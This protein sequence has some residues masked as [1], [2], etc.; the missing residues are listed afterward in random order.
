M[1]DFEVVHNQDEL[2]KDLDERFSSISEDR[3]AP[4]IFAGG[5]CNIMVLPQIYV[6][7]LVLNK[8]MKEKQQQ[9]DATPHGCVEI[10]NIGTRI[11]GAYVLNSA[12]QEQQGPLNKM[13]ASLSEQEIQ[14]EL[15][16]IAQSPVLSVQDL[17]R[18]SD[19]QMEIAECFHNMKW[20]ILMDLVLR[21]KCAEKITV[22]NE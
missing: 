6:S 18:M 14:D 5:Q 22:I 3:Y 20:D 12:Q 1:N 17:L 19:R 21:E 7:L 16:R 8:V 10:S 9:E 13:L 15:I 11:Q 2:M 4:I